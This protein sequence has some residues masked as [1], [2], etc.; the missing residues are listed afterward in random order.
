MDV[1]ASLEEMGY[2][3][4]TRSNGWVRMKPLYRDSSSDD[5]LSVN[6]K[7]GR[8][9]DF[10]LSKSFDF[11]TLVSLTKGIKDSEAE[12]WI[13][14]LK[15]TFKDTTPEIIHYENPLPKSLIHDLEK[16]YSYWNGRGISDKVLDLFD[17]GV[18]RYG[19]LKDRFVFRIYSSRNRIIG[20]D[21]RDLINN[22]KKH[23]QRA[24]WKKIGKQSEWFY[25]RF[26]ED[27][28]RNK[29]VILVES[30]GDLLS[31]M[32]SGFYNC[33]PCF[34]KHMSKTVI[35]NLIR[36]NPKKI[37]VSFNNDENQQGQ[38]GMI[39]TKERLDKFFSNVIIHVPSMNDYNEMLTKVGK[40]NIQKELENV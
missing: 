12:Q 26:N 13:R 34:T 28:I 21:G 27:E 14:D 11:K 31:L 32:E 2:R 33:I 37:I 5:V 6:L 40:I 17:C 39:K 20:M 1:L 30:F 24:K 36:L 22:S 9:R 7:T 8:A 35:T 23:P 19:E 4:T 16:D 18:C 15:I 3:I 38:N 25:P 29:S 10:S